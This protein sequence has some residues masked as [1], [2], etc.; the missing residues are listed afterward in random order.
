MSDN[1]AQALIRITKQQAPGQDVVF[2][3]EGT[4]GADGVREF[5]GIIASS[6]VRAPF[7][8]DVSGIVGVQPAGS[9]FLKEL[10]QAGCR[11]TGGS[12]YINRLLGVIES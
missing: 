1:G 3:V 12:M 9:A 7:T 5:R 10:K 8:V 4:L 2:R 11:L 6:D